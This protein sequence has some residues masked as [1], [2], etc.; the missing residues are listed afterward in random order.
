M[1]D[2]DQLPLAARVFGHLLIHASL[3]G[4]GVAEWGDMGIGLVK[5]EFDQSEFFKLLSR[6]AWQVASVRNRLAG[7]LQPHVEASTRRLLSNSLSRPAEAYEGLFDYHRLHGAERL[8][9]ELGGALLDDLL[10]ADGSFLLLE[11]FT[12]RMMHLIERY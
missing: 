12:H 6:V 10:S 9:L 5:G 4:L 1:L 2:R 8:A 7:S 3:S 11:D